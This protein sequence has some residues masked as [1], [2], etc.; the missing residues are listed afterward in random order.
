MDLDVQAQ[1]D[2][3]QHEVLQGLA[4]QR[5]EIPRAAPGHR[6]SANQPPAASWGQ[7]LS[8]FM[9]KLAGGAVQAG[10]KIKGLVRS[11]HYCMLA[12]G[13]SQTLE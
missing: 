3:R 5:L 4:R 8:D 10:S 13:S 9:E 11:L 2:R 6:H 12:N 7:K 1:R